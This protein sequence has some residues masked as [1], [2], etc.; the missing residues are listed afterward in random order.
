[1][2]GTIRKV[3]GIGLIGL[4]ECRGNED[5]RDVFFITKK[6]RK[7]TERQIFV[8]ECAVHRTYRLKIYTSRV[9]PGNSVFASW[10]SNT[11]SYCGSF[12]LNK[13]SRK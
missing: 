2:I 12:R 5:D 6:N 1:M 3:K 7:Y 11:G 10:I 9:L 4:F 13:S 8:T